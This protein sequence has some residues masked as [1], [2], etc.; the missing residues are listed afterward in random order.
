M[1]KPKQIPINK[2]IQDYKEKYSQI[3]PIMSPALKQKVYFN[4][5]GFKHLIFKGPRRRSNR[6]IINRLTLIP[7]IPPVIKNA[8][9]I[10]ETRVS[11]KLVRGKSMR[12]TFYSIE[13][14]VGK[15][16]VIVKI[17]VRKIGEKGNLFFYSIMKQ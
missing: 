14:G 12:I 3:N 9:H 4:M 8:N 10:T 11:Y 2:L 16:N 15:S 13:A 1:N 6:D 7:L 17:V 5:A